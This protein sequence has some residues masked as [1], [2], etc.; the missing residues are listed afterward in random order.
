MTKSAGG[1]SASHSGVSAPSIAVL[2]PLQLDMSV[3]HHLHDARCMAVE[4]ERFVCKHIYLH[5]FLLF[6]S[7]MVI[8]HPLK[9]NFCAFVNQDYVPVFGQIL[10]SA[11]LQVVNACYKYYFIEYIALDQGLCPPLQDCIP[12]QI[13]SK[14]RCT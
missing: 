4:E 14:I 3:W 13:S 11:L 12:C 9:Q 2:G 10:S 5:K 8:T 1:L 7:R 6:Y